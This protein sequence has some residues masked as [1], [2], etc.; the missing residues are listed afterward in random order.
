[1]FVLFVCFIYLFPFCPSRDEKNWGLR[2]RGALQSH[3]IRFSRK[4]ELFAD[5]RSFGG[6]ICCVDFP[7]GSKSGVCVRYFKRTK[8]QHAY[9][10]S[11]RANWEKAQWNPVHVES[12]RCYC[13]TSIH[14]RCNLFFYLYR[15]Y[16]I[17]LSFFV[18]PF[19]AG[20]SVLCV[21]TLRAEGEKTS[22][23]S[24]RKLTVARK[25]KKSILFPPI[26]SST[27]KQAQANLSA[28]RDLCVQYKHS[29]SDI[30]STLFSSFDTDSNVL[31]LL[32]LD[33]FLFLHD[34]YLIQ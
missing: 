5:V 9:V 20:Y 8:K 18:T 31:F 21:S 17:H 22:A 23:A 32:L 11:Q 28:R 13:L 12:I 15:R 3:A 25:E 34:F 10:F 30:I 29:G 27:P 4:M 6:R 7:K 19:V 2:V 33:F 16:S 14:S 1:M 26:V 24:S